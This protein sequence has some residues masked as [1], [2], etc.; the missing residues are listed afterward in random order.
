MLDGIL[1]LPALRT[2]EDL[3][4]THYRFKADIVLVDVALTGMTG[5]EAARWI[6]EQRPETRIIC[7]TR[8][9]NTEILWAALLSGS[10]GCILKR[11]AWSSIPLFIQEKR[12]ITP[13]FSHASDIEP[14]Q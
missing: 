4:N 7:L 6:K 3:V 12:K 8:T 11:T 9:Y 10:E 14:V 13:L 1:V 5:I 2:G